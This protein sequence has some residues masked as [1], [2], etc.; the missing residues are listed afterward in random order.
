MLSFLRS[1]TVLFSADRS[2]HQRK[3]LLY[4]ILANSLLLSCT[5]TLGA[6]L[7]HVPQS[8]R[9]LA[10]IFW[11]MF[12]CAEVVAIVWLGSVVFMP[13]DSE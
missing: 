1:S 8:G 11:L 12:L 7:P 6:V 4:L 2:P 10:L 5:I 13:R 9:N 3:D